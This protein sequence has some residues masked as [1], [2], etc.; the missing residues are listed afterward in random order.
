MGHIPARKNNMS[1]IVNLNKDL[2][3]K[4]RRVAEENSDLSY[5]FIKDIFLGLE[6]VKE[7]NLTRYHKEESKKPNL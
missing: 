7:G 1:I 4:A 3:D 5:S 6:D 2:V